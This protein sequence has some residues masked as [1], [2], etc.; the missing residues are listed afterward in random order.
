TEAAP[1]H[2][3]AGKIKALA[4]LRSIGPEFSTTLVGEVFYR[5][6]TNQRQIGSYV[7][8]APSP[9][10]SGPTDRDQ[11]ISKASN[12]KARSTMI[13]L[14]WM[15]L[16]YPPDSTLSIALRQRVGGRTVHV[17]RISSVALARK[18]MVALWRHLES[19]LVPAG[20]VV[21]PR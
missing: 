18:P 12:P 2:L 10:S 6:F 16:R 5:S 4:N 11:G 1:R 21:K 14:A 3:N 9:F 8:L 13:E 20:A 17:P 7:G 19:R 15:S